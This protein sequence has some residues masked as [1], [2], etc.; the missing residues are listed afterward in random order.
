MRIFTGT[1]CNFD[2]TQDFFDRDS[3]LT[4]RGFESLGV[5]SGSITLGP[6]KSGDLPAMRRATWNELESPAWWSEQHLDGLVFYTWGNPK[7][8]RMVSAA[9]AAGI[10]VAQFTDSQGIISPLADWKAHIRSEEAYLWHKP[11]WVRLLRKS[12]KLAYS[13]SLRIILR[14]RAIVKTILNGDL[15]LSAS[16]NSEI[17]YRK[18]VRMIS[19]YD[20]AD[21]VHYVPLPVNWH[22]TFSSDI[23][24]TNDIVAIG[25]WDSDQKRT[26]LLISTIS[27]FLKMRSDVRFR[28]FGNV[29]PLLREWHHQL[30]SI[31]RS[32]VCLEGVVSNQELATPLQMAKIILVSSAYESFHIASAEAVCCGASV[33]ACRSPFLDTLAWHASRNSG[34]IASNATPAGLSNALFCELSAWDNGDRDPL[35]ISKSWSDEFHPDRV[36]ARILELLGL[37]LAKSSNRNAC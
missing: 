32:K 14:D 15:F 31:E 8:L 37:P 2:G 7:Y 13:H 9:K 26:P 24:K 18:L 33:V 16:P 10:R 20:P 34:T 27:R 17:R 1:P 6:E 4:M 5:H 28:I 21:R 19:G 30:S 12:A 36:A 11:V 22:F 29:C 3:G 23:Q 35:A 25:R